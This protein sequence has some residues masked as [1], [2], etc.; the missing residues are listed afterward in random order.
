MTDTQL[1]F[2]ARDI[3][4][5]AQKKILSRMTNKTVAKK[6]IDESTASLLDNIYRL[7]K[8]HVSKSVLSTICT[9]ESN[10]LH[11]TVYLF[12]LENK[13]EAE[14]LVK[15]MIKTVIKIGILYRN[16]EFSEE[17]LQLAD[18]FRHK[19]LQTQKTIICFQEVEFSFDLNYLQNS[20]NESRD[21]LKSLV[22]RHLTEK[23]VLRI[24]EVFDFF[25]DNRLLEIAFKQNSPYQDVMNNIVA[26]MNKSLDTENSINTGWV[27]D[28]HP[29]DM[30]KGNAIRITHLNWR[31]HLFGVLKA[32]SLLN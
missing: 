2:K 27:Q 4:L 31:I 20:M 13:R 1:P 12:Q 18:R 24:D 11:F 19:F 3:G 14:R 32:R 8:L 22:K 29:V 26:D 25:C 17:E 23:S 21:L 28:T 7:A 10:A 16:D 6:F 5:R 15:N 9:S 30:G